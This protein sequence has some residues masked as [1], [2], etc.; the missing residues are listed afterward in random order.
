MLLLVLFSTER[1]ADTRKETVIHKIM[2]KEKVVK[3]KRIY[4][5]TACISAINLVIKYIGEKIRS[6][7]R[8]GIKELPFYNRLFSQ[9]LSLRIIIMPHSTAPG[10]V[11]DVRYFIQRHN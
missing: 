1:V 7:E 4:D 6:Y 9:F 11:S 3:T 5:G 2:R 8:R 10:G